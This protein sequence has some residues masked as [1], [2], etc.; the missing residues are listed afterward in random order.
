[1][2]EV[3][4]QIKDLDPTHP[5]VTKNGRWTAAA[6][7]ILERKSMPSRYRS[8][9][10][11][12]ENP[13]R[14]TKLFNRIAEYIEV[15]PEA[16]N[17]GA[18]GTARDKTPCGTAFCIAGHAVHETNW[19]PE[20]K[21]GW[22]EVLRPS[23]VNPWAVEEAAALE[24]GITRVEWSVLFSGG[25]KPKSGMTVPEALRALGNGERV[26][27]VTSATTLNGLGY[28]A[29]DLEYHYNRRSKI[30]VTGA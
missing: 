21:Y 12:S 5:A 18:W 26:D 16:H 19:N 24:L 13:V 29:D 15:F 2:P 23:M 10:Q 4:L 11:P 20:M 8:D 7:R 27:S 9:R 6:K 30:R 28:L 3:T 14:N 17:Q 1:M 25:W 22:E